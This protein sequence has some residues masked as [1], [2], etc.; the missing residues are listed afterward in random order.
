[1][2]ATILKFPAKPPRRELSDKTEKRLQELVDLLCISFGEE[3]GKMRKTILEAAE[4]V[5]G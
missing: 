3:P 2:S 5:R 4:Q 1:M